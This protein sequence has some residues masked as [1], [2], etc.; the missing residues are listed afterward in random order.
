M[1]SKTF[2]AVSLLAGLFV[3]QNPATAQI[4]WDPSHTGGTGSGG[5]GTW[6]TAANWYNGSADVGWVANDIAYF[7][8]T[9]GTVTLGANE[10]ADGL[11]FTTTG[12]II[13][14]DTITLAGSAPSITVPSA[15]T[16]TINSILA[17][18][19]GLTES[20]AGSSGTLIL[21]ATNTYTGDTTVPAGGTLEITT[22]G[23]RGRDLGSDHP[24]W[25]CRPQR[26]HSRH[27][28]YYGDELD[29]R[30]LEQCH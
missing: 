8:G 13:K 3:C 24:Q 11:I 30:R 12:Y 27:S 18:S 16:E 14:T 5:A 10:T 28:E 7:E 21:N 17:G 26:V 19:A 23:G 22:G 25:Q 1:T 4:Y 6:S 2:T 15:G 20:L 29:H 9:A